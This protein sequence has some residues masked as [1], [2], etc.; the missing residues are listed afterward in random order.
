M[1]LQEEIQVQI[2]FGSIFHN[3]KIQATPK[4]E[5]GGRKASSPWF[6]LYASVSRKK[7][8]AIWRQ[9]F[10]IQSQKGTYFL[11]STHHCLAKY[12]WDT[13]YFVPYTT[14]CP[15]HTGCQAG[16]GRTGITAF[17]RASLAH[18]KECLVV[19]AFGVWCRAYFVDLERRERLC[20]ELFGMRSL[21]KIHD[22]PIGK[23]GLSPV[24]LGFVL[25]F[26]A[27]ASLVS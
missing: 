19:H 9:S 14:T 5:I 12:L 4:S 7:I 24:R 27:E 2:C 22:N 6:Q 16:M 23:H 10:M 21:V 13:L 1:H 25:F 26:S 8:V 11:S 20:S 17:R 15:I 18:V 3:P